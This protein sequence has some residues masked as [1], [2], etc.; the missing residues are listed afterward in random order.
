M[1]ACHETIDGG[2]GLVHRWRVTQVTRLG[3]PGLLA[4]AASASVAL[5]P[6]RARRGLARSVAAARLSRI[7]VARS[8]M[9]MA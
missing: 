8:P 2:E 7:M 9:V 3:I 4:Q 1:P 5:V 6:D